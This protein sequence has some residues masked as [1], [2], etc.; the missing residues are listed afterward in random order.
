MSQWERIANASGELKDEVQTVV[1]GSG[2]GGSVIAARLAEKGHPVC[3][4]ERGKEWRPGG[5]P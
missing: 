1:V 2:Y 5:L 3:L 4:L